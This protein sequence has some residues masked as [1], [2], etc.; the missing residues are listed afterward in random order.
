MET[1]FAKV[2]ASSRRVKVDLKRKRAARCETYLTGGTRLALPLRSSLNSSIQKHAKRRKLLGLKPMCTNHISRFRK[3]LLKSYLNLK[4]TGSPQRLMYY[5]NGEWTDYP[6]DLVVLL[7]KDFQVKKFANEVKFNGRSIV[8]DFLHM[9]QFDLETGLQQPIA[10][11]DEVGNC[12][13]PETFTDYDEIHDCCCDNE[14][15]H[16]HSFSPL[17]GSNEMKL[18]LEIEINGLDSS[19]L[20]ESSGESNALEM[21]VQLD[22]KPATACR[23]AEVDDNFGKISDTEVNIISEKSLVRGALDVNM[24]REIFVKGLGSSL[25][26]AIVDISRGL[27][28]AMQARS[29]LFQKQAEI[30]KKYRGDANVRYGW[31]PTSKEAVAGIMT[32]GLGHGGIN[33]IK[34]IYGAGTYLIPA[35]CTQISASYCD[36]DENGAQ[37]MVLC[38]VIM[39]NMELV[40]HGSK[41]FHPSSEDFDSGV[42]DLQNPGFYVVWNMNMNT[43]IF[44]EY[45]VSF[46]IPSDTEGLLVENESKHATSGVSTCCQ[47][48]QVQLDLNS[49]PVDVVPVQRSREIVAKQ[50]SGPAKTPRSPWMPFPLLFAAISSKVTPRD[51]DLVKTNYE[52]FRMKQ[53]SRDEFVK[54]LRLI[55]GDNLLRS[56]ITNLQR[57]IPSNMEGDF[58]LPKQEQGEIQAAQ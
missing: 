52:L 7:K 54:R 42:D 53:I 4:K 45:T 40:C 23:A 56:A 14:R 8:L 57:K 34:S 30:T 47:G 25:D 9:L 26:V 12:F 39:G 16:G 35:D 51:M 19:K 1:K 15:D 32:Y 24:V 43:H 55:V 50:A 3:S 21:K 31:L 36:V 29:E 44:P 58:V 28:P 22:Q 41:Q 18:Q 11:I 20:K 6:Q 5:Q 2:L 10:W 49:T 48:P 13:F 17:H 27:G 33:K 46:K 38:R 37:H